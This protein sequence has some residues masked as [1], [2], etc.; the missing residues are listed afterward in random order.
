MQ[1]ATQLSLFIDNRPGVL[2]RVCEALAEAGVN[3]H[4]FTT[5]DAVDHMVIR[6]VVNHTRKAVEV[7]EARHALVVESEVLM[8]PG[9]N[10][11]GSLAEIARRLGDAKINI[12]YAYCATSP[13]AR[14]GLLI[15]HTNNCKKA[16]K[17]L[18]G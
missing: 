10:K 7:F 15:L 9:D 8:V 11:P 6:M 17:V 4:A 14:N 3:I 18:N 5:N 16:M 1:L 13:G 12:D 2:G